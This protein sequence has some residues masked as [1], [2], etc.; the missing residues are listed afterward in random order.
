MGKEAAPFLID[1]ASGTCPITLYILTLLDFMWCKCDFSLKFA[2]KTKISLMLW[3][4]FK[5]TITWIRKILTGISW[6]KR[7]FSC[8]LVAAHFTMVSQWVK[9]WIFWNLNIALIDG[10]LILTWKGL[11]TS[12][13][14]NFCHSDLCNV[15]LRH[16]HKPTKFPVNNLNMVLKRIS[17]FHKFIWVILDVYKSEKKREIWYWED[18]NWIHR[19]IWYKNPEIYLYIYASWKYHPR[20]TH[21]FTFSASNSKLMREKKKNKKKKKEKGVL[22]LRRT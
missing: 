7:E 19:V 2:Y 10:Q 21:H 17:W 1:N 15:F 11:L 9:P 4:I 3:N 12:S 6:L 22:R 16:L 14:R 5:R 13:D 8:D 18:W 20:H